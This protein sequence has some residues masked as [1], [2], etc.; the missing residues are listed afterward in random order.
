MNP[1]VKKLYADAIYF[2]L[3]HNG[4]SPIKASIEAERIVRRLYRE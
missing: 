1:E 4:L 3:I 2:H